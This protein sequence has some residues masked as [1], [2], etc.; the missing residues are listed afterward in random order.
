MSEPSMD[1]L[2]TSID[3][4]LLSRIRRVRERF[5]RKAEVSFD[6]HDTAAFLIEQLEQLPLD[7]LTT[8][9]AGTG[10]VALLR[11]A[12]GGRTVAVRAEMDGLPIEERTGLEYS[13][14]DPGSMHACGHDGHMAIVLGLARLFCDMRQRLAG[15]VKFVFQPGEEEGAGARRVI[16]CGGLRDPDVDAILAVHARPQIRAGQIELDEVPSAYADGFDVSIEGTSSHGAYPHLGRDAVLIA[17]QVVCNLQQ[18]VS[19]QV[20]PQ[21]AAVVTVGAMGVG[22]A[23]NVIADRAWLKGTIR[24]RHPEVRRKVIHAVEQI[25]TRTAG[26]LGGSATV[27]LQTGYPRVR[28]DPRLLALMRRLGREL[29]G[30]EN[31]LESTDATMGADDF[32]YYLSEQGGVPGCLVRL[33]VET[34]QPLHT[35]GFDFGHRA[36]EPG[37]LLLAN[38]CLAILRGEGVR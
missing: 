22:R 17:S 27:D 33:G 38:T 34:D 37:I 23:R 36:L 15:A 8:G 5:H 7:G 31:V 29:F 19:R 3:P 13:S 16:Q 30:P 6:E 28:N 20:A 21:Q 4:D 11:G 25:A 9:V 32:S 10:V 2:M 1:D 24:T 14:A 18:V 26:A 12:G 35:D